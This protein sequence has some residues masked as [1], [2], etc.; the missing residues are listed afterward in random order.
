MT[1]QYPTAQAA[2]G[3]VVMC[4]RSHMQR[5]RPSVSCAQQGTC[6]THAVRAERWGAR[7][8]QGAAAPRSF[9]AA[10]CMRHAACT[11]MQQTTPPYA[12]CA[13]HGGRAARGAAAP[14]SFT[15]ARRHMQQTSHVLRCR[16][17]PP[18][19]EHGGRA[20]RGAAAAGAAAASGRGGAHVVQ[21]AGRAVAGGADGGGA[22]R[23]GHL[24]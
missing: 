20:A 5:S 18:R 8:A 23:G 14:H 13:E 9:T 19:A 1:W 11:C 4:L 15:A 17:P 10:R 24:G 3:T 7:A 16:E 22:G 21:H 12:I 6:M 2:A